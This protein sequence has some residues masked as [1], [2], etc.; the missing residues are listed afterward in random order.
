MSSKLVHLAQADHNHKA[1]R[2]L[3]NTDFYDWAC[4]AAFYTAIHYIEAKFT[5]NPKILHTKDQY[6]KIK[7]N[8]GTR[9]EHA[10]REELISG[11]FS[12]DLYSRFRNLR[13]MSENARYLEKGDNISTVL[14][15]KE[16]VESCLQKDLE[17]IKKELGY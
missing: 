7:Y 5:E 17:E 1:S 8:G 4:T 13:E 6:N 11:S 2:E 16:E 15:K 10:F 14:I 12:E 9:G 3:V